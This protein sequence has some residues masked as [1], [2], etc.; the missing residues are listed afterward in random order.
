MDNFGAF[1]KA[2]MSFKQSFEGRF[3]LEETLCEGSFMV[4]ALQQQ[5]WEVRMAR[6]M[7]STSNA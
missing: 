5:K 1:D 4:S 6:S 7:T 2:Y 3:G